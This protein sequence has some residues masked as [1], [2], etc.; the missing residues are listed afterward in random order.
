MVRDQRRQRIELAHLEKESAKNKII[1]S[2]R[3]RSYNIELQLGLVSPRRVNEEKFSKMLES[4][5]N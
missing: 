3:E 1:D 5:G 4:I 2:I